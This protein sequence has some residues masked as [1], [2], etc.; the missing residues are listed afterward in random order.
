MQ[1]S[2]AMDMHAKLQ[3]TIAM[4]KIK[5]VKIIAEGGVDVNKKFESGL[6]PIVTACIENNAQI[7]RILLD[8]G[9]DLTTRDSLGQTVF[10]YAYM[11]ENP[12]IINLLEERRFCKQSVRISHQSASK[13]RK[14]KRRFFN[15]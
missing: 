12:D 14:F 11:C 2:V 8:N 1:D 7:V 15:R 3:A 9:A 6:T 5:L 4:N 10:H 13:T